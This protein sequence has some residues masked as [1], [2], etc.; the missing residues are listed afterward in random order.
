[1]A[2]RGRTLFTMRRTAA[3]RH[4]HLTNAVPVK[5]KEQEIAKECCKEH[6]PSILTLPGC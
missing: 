5:L 3:Q 4:M 6:W 2:L 1:M